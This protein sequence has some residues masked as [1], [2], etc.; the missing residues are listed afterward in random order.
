MI[1]TILTDA[2]V[3]RGLYKLVRQVR[4]LKR[5][6]VEIGIGGDLDHFSGLAAVLPGIPLSAAECQKWSRLFEQLPPIYKWVPGGLR[7]VRSCPRRRSALATNRPTRWATRGASPPLARSA[8]WRFT[9]LPVRRPK[10]LKESRR[11]P[12]SWRTLRI[13]SSRASAGS[14]DAGSHRF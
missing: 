9:I 2:A 13:N 10:A 14:A 5:R 4:E 8:N 11:V 7:Q 12:S 6:D 1:A 3:F